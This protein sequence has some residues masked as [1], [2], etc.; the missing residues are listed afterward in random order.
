MP[1]TWRRRGI[2]EWDDESSAGFL[3]TS[4][5]PSSLKVRILTSSPGS[6]VCSALCTLSPGGRWQGS[7]QE[8]GHLWLGPGQRDPSREEARRSEI[9]PFVLSVLQ[10]NVQLFCRCY[11]E[12]QN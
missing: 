3:P 12:A 11:R 2:R 8:P 1:E 6:E 7:S 10:F 5:I 4:E 9:T